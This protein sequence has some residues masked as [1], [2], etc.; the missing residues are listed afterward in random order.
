MAFCGSRKGYRI[1]TYAFCTPK[2]M[3]LLRHAIPLFCHPLVRPMIVVL[4]SG[5]RSFLND[6]S[7]AVDCKAITSSR[8]YSY[9]ITLGS[10]GYFHRQI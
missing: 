9:V 8:V 10:Y 3:C 6:A 1:R 5:C 2:H 7:Y 4:A